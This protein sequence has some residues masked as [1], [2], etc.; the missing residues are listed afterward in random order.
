V[1]AVAGTPGT[2]PTNWTQ[3]N[4]TGLGANV[5]GTGT[6]N[7]ITYIDLQIN[8]TTTGSGQTNIVLETILGIAAATGQTWSLSPYLKIQ[9]GSLTNVGVVNLVLQENTALGTAVTA[10]SQAVTIPASSLGTYRPTFTRTLS[11][12]VTVA[13][14]M[15]YIQININTG[16]V[17]DFTLRIGLPQLEQGAFATSP[18]LT[19]TA[20]VT[21]SADVCSIT[22]SAFSSWYSQ[23]EGTVFSTYQQYATGGN[24]VNINDGTGSNFINI[25]TSAAANAKGSCNVFVSGANNGRLDSGGTF[26][27]N[28]PGSAAY[29]LANGSRSFLFTSGTTGTS[30]TPA[31]MP[32]VN[33]LRI[34]CDANNTSHHNG[35]IRRLTYWPTRLSNASLQSIT[36]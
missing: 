34:G 28:T 3:S 20:A 5:V 18:I 29:A 36:Q 30:A 23:S 11:G 14:L 6:E 16:L 32:T 33:Q 25:F 12:G 21:R 1:G 15:P 31:T 2:L 13:A 10:G 9:A 22:G 19:S 26:A 4:N 7:G 24:V 27:A 8:G 17:V 35:T